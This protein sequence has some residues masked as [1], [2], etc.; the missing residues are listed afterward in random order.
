MSKHR[1]YDIA[2]ELNTDNKTILDILRKNNIEVKS[3]SSTVDDAARQLVVKAVKGNSQPG[4]KPQPQA[5]A[6]QQVAAKVQQAVQ[7]M[8]RQKQVQPQAQPQQKK[9]EQKS[10]QQPK[11]Q[12]QQAKQQGQQPQKNGAQQKQGQAKHGGSQPDDRRQ[13][14]DGQKQAHQGGQNSGGRHDRNDRNDRNDGRNGGGKP[15]QRNGRNES[16]RGGQN[17]G[18]RND[19]ADRGSRNDK[20]D[21]N[22]K[23]DKR[24]NRDNRMERADRMERNDR[25]RQNGGGRNERNDRNGKNGRNSFNNNNNNNNNGRNN[26][27]KNNRGGRNQQPAPKMEIARPKNI[28][29]GETIIV[30][31]LASKM[32]C[33]AAEIIK[34][35]MLMGV[36]ASINQE[37]DFDTAALVAS[38]FGVNVEELPPEVDPTLIPEIVDDPK[39]LVLR[40]PVVTVMGHVDHGKTSLLDVIRKTSVTSHEAGGITQ[41][42]GAYQVKCQGK[43]IVFLDTPGHEAFTAMRARGAQ[44]TDIAILVVAADDGVMPQTIEAI[45]HA[46]DADVPIIVAVNKIDKPGANPANVKNELMEH[47]LV[48]EEYGGDTIM[49][50]VSAKKNI[51]I[52]DL[53]EMVLLVAEMKELKANPKREARG[54]IIE[55][56]LDK[57]RGPVATVLVQSGTLRIGDSIV[58]GTTYGKVRAMLNDRGENVKKAGPSVPV[59]VLG[60]NDVPAAGD[61]LAA[62]EEKQARTIAEKR[63][64]KQRNE[65]I[66]AK[67]VSLDDLFNQIQEGQLKDLNIVVKADV[68]GSVEALNSSLLGLNKNDEVRVRIVHS[69]VGAVTESDVMLASASNALVIAFNVRP[70]ANARRV[71]DAEAIDIRTYRVIYD[72]LNDVKD[73]MSGML[74]PK[75]KEVIQGKVEIRQVMKFS[76]ALV[77]GSYVLEGKITNQSKIRIVRDNIEVFDGELDGLRRFKDDVK[78][79]AAGYECG[80]TIKDYK[81]FREGDIIEAYIMEEVKTS[82]NDVNKD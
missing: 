65:M 55:A 34:K 19:H 50:E 62:L 27:G 26:R 30:K 12:A 4:A 7:P 40:P 77:A 43:K 41:H 72:A 67:K 63:M 5:A 15:G 8:N 66:H 71:A 49:V 38:E 39:S 14:H 29:V 25:N 2:K 35:L 13:K 68:Q 37:I 16:Q 21:R 1:V 79:V 57:G 31:D 76:K 28:K 48:P 61:E 56:Q 11:A 60:L 36:L 45:H 69:G 59:E 20:G 3:H 64:E 17:S 52:N 23:N 78:E 82:I 80:I 9:Q 44:V 33:T 46:K 74:A 81:D 6:K 22:D 18:N 42:I 70:D 75:Y 73:A 54:V 51:G 47:G 58:A 53:L 32:S 10:G 24:N